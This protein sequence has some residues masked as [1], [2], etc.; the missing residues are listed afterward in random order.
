[1]ITKFEFRYVLL[2]DRDCPESAEA[3]L[4]K[5]N[6]VEKEGGRGGRVRVYDSPLE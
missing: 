4:E 6:L 3:E 5:D 2:I 1:V